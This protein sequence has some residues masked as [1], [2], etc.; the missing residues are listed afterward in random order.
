MRP[1]LGVRTLG[2]PLK[3]LMQKVPTLTLPNPQP[4]YFKDSHI[5]ASYSKLAVKVSYAKEENLHKR[6][7]NSS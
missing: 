7:T 4:L 3:F 5:N 2:Q 6:N 1:T